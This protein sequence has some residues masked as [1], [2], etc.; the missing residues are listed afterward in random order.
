MSY[1]IKTTV[2]TIEINNVTNTAITAITEDEEQG[3]YYREIR[4][5]AVPTGSTAETVVITLRIRGAASDDI[6]LDVPASTF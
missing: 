4:I 6:E 1:E 5:F 3:D 2:Q